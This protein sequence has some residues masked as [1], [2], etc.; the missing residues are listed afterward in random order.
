MMDKSTAMNLLKNT[1][2]DYTLIDGT[3]VKLTLAFALLKMLEDKDANLANRYYKV[4]SK[5]ESEMRE[6]DIITMLYTAYFCAC[7]AD[8]AEAMDEDTFMI[9]LGSDRLSL[10]R[11][12][13]QLMGAKKNPASVSHS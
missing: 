5:K 7:I 6:L 12:F 2:V 11:I 10:K 9:L 3:T 13:N 1:F 4:T 8:G